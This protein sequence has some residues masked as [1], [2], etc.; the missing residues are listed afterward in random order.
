MII[1]PV[2]RLTLRALL[3][4][5]RTILLGLLA[6]APVLMAFVY[7]V[8]ANAGDNHLEFYSHLVQELF[9]PTIGAVVATVCAATALTTVGHGL[10]PPIMR[11]DQYTPVLPVVT[12]GV[13]LGAGLL[14]VHGGGPS[15]R[16]GMVRDGSRDR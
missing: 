8:A 3:L 6:A 1:G 14:V 2:F 7:A 9:V 15:R 16:F 10:L 13:C 11:G 12:A 4:Q 5:R